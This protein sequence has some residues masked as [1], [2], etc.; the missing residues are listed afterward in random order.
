[1][2]LALFTSSLVLLTISSATAQNSDNNDN[3]PD[4]KALVVNLCP[5][6]ALTFFSFK[7]D[8][9]R[10]SMKLHYRNVSQQALIALEIVVLKYDAF[11]RRL[12]GND[13]TVTGTNSANW[14]PLPPGEGGRKELIGNGREEVFTA[15][16]YVRA[17]RLADGTVWRVNDLQLLAGLRKV[18]PE[19]TEFG[20]VGPAPKTNVQ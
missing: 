16:A 14:A 18:A 11:N 13:M 8:S 15:I 10:H 19:F 3:Y 17:A 9:G 2:K 1:M 7:N 20:G 12:I 5:H 6:V 4:R